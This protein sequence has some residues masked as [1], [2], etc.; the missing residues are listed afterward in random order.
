MSLFYR[1]SREIC[2][3]EIETVSNYVKETFTVDLNLERLKDQIEN[4]V[5]EKV[6]AYNHNRF[7]DW[8]VADLL[9][10]SSVLQEKLTPVTNNIQ[11]KKGRKRELK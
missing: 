11:E 4:L 3:D 6:A 9:L 8:T 1:K 2:L 5:E 7:K 10:L